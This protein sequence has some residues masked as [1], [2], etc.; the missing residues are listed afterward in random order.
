LDITTVCVIGGSGFIGRHVCHQLA[1]QGYRVRVPT[2][3]RERAKA[4]ILLPTVDVVEAISMM[5][6]SCRRSSPAVTR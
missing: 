4:L 5:P 3:D 2:R 6:G 1:A